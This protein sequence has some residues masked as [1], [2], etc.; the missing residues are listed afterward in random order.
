MAAVPA[1]AM[2]IGA[3]EPEPQG[4]VVRLQERQEK[5]IG[6][7]GHQ[8]QLLAFLPVPQTWTLEG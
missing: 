7:R 6:Q 3:Q 1:G 2:T 8:E 5:G 4:I